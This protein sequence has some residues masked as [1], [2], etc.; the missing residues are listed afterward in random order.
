MARERL[1]ALA[2]RCGISPGLLESAE[3]AVIFFSLHGVADDGPIKFFGGE[4]CAE[5]DQRG[6]WGLW[7]RLANPIVFTKWR[8]FWRAGSR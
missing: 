6:Y 5:Q 3:R 8:V 7:W 1:G 2:Y 4:A